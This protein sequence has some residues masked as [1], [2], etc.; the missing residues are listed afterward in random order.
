M[1]SAMEQTELDEIKADVKRSG[2]KAAERAAKQ[3]VAAALGIEFTDE[4][5]DGAA[6]AEHYTAAAMNATCAVDF[7]ASTE[8]KEMKECR[9]KVDADNT[10][11]KKP[12]TT[13]LGLRGSERAI[14]L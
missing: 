4:A 12:M 2:V 1:S 6:E 7:A 14:I 5:P 11:T 9:T 3:A 13:P 8:W 10:E